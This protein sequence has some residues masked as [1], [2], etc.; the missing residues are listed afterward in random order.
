MA[1]L[2][3]E[4]PTGLN[5]QQT[6]EVKVVAVRCYSA[7]LLLAAAGIVIMGVFA[8]ADAGMGFAVA[9]AAVGGV[10]H[11]M[12]RESLEHGLSVLKG[13]KGRDEK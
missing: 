13:V 9:I 8:G 11:Y 10:L 6:S 5:E 12:P 7:G 3:I 1:L 4:K 2:N